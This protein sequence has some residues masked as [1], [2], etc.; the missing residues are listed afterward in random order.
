MTQRQISMGAGL[1]PP[2]RA[3]EVA[4]PRPDD[5][6]RGLRRLLGALAVASPVLFATFVALDPSPLPR[7][8]AAEFLGAIADAPGQYV[9]ATCFQIAAMATGL[10]LA[11]ALGLAFR[12]S[13]R[14]LSAV[15]AAMLALGCLGGAGFAGGKLAAADLVVDGELRPGAV[16]YWTAVQSGPLFDVMSWPLVMAILG[17][18]LAT[19]VLVRARREIS[20]WPAAVYL[21]GFVMSS[22]EFPDAI[23]FAGAV[24]QVPAVAMIART[25][26]RTP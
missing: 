21:A 5:V 8:P 9:L 4:E 26:W 20:W 6:R 24:V 19:A 18:L 1:L 7:E 11:V 22:G 3:V 12:R 25:L 23:T 13:S 16:E 15:A 17:T 2:Q 10:A 14:R